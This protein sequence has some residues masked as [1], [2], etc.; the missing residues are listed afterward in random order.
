[1]QLGK[2][3]NTEVSSPVQL[4][5]LQADQDKKVSINFLE[6]RQGAL[7]SQK[8]YKGTSPKEVEYIVIDSDPEDDLAKSSSSSPSITVMSLSEKKESV[9]DRDYDLLL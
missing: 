4:R 8:L 5:N 3:T 2:A 1:M 7:L 6:S 9:S